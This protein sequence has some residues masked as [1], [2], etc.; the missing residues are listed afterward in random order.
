MQQAVRKINLHVYTFMSVKLY[1]VMDLIDQS[2]IKKLIVDGCIVKIKSLHQ[3]VP[4]A[5]SATLWS[6]EYKFKMA[7]PRAAFIS[8]FTTTITVSI[9]FI[10]HFL[11][12]L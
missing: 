12:K 1:L 5:S 7:A 6:A 9:R 3:W 2:K 8:P 10:C 4:C 11:S